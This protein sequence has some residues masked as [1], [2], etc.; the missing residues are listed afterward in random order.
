MDIRDSGSLLTNTH[1]SCRKDAAAF[2][3]QDKPA[4]NILGGSCEYKGLKVFI[5][6]PSVSL[7]ISLLCC[8]ILVSLCNLAFLQ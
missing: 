1:K 2:L 7:M 5:F 3:A 6:H 4:G 8:Y